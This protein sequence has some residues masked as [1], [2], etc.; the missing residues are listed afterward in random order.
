MA[1]NGPQ[2][3]TYNRDFIGC[4]LE[5]EGRGWISVRALRRE[6][7]AFLFGSNAE[8]LRLTGG[9]AAEWHTR[10]KPIHRAQTV[11]D[12]SNTVQHRNGQIYSLLKSHEPADFRQHHQLKPALFTI[13][14]V[15]RIS[16]R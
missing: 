11:S 13:M 14:A 2:Q 8:D 15:W 1:F 9:E 16:G 4:Q 3:H 6:R 7:A 12:G 5:T 10:R